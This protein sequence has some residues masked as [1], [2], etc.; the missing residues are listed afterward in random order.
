MRRAALVFGA[1]GLWIGAWALTLLIW[2]EAAVPLI[3]FGGA[4]AA[5]AL[6][7]GYLVVAAPPEDPPRTLTDTSA[8]PPLIAA[9]IV[10]AANGLAFGLWLILIGAEVAA[11][12]GGLLIAELWRAR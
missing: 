3:A 1:W 8:A 4:A 12:G 10:L 2:G 7:A 11:F 9:G 5:T 6:A